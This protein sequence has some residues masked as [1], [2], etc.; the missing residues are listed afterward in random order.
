MKRLAVFPIIGLL[1]LA[2]TSIHAQEANTILIDGVVIDENGEAAPFVNIANISSNLG[3]ASNSEGRF[4]IV[5]GQE[6]S[7]LF[8]SIG[9]KQYLFTL[10]E[11]VKTKQLDITIQLNTTSLELAPVKVFAY[12]DER[13]LKQAILDLNVPEEKNERIRIPGVKYG[14]RREVKPGINGL[15][16]SG[17]ISIIQNMFSKKAKEIKKYAKVT[18]EHHSWKYN[19]YDKY[20]PT[21]VKEITGLPEDEVDDFMK[22]CEIGDSFIRL[23][24]QYEIV[25]AVQQCYDNY[26]KESEEEQKLEN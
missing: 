20:N 2:Y 18:K 5:M 25:V 23:S 3:T 12:R 10:T 11:S 21:I 17:P 13:A 22:F 8:S 24:N 26:I 1:I 15:G 9:F 7:L 4:A 14:E 19:V 16:I 6:D